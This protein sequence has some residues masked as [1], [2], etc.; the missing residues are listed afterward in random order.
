M[1]YIAY[2]NLI[3]VTHSEEQA[4]EEA[5]SVMVSAPFGQNRVR[6]SCAVV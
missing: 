3:G 2:R 1:Q 5:E 6:P 4:K